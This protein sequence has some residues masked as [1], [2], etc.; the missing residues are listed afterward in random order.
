MTR[1]LYDLAA[2]DESL[3][4]SPYCWRAKL[5]LAHKNLEYETV[6]WH[7]TDKAAIAFSGGDKVP[8]LVDG[9]KVIADSQDIAEYL[10]ETYANEPPLFGEAPARALTNFIRAWTDRV[11]IPALAPILVPD[12]F[13]RLAEQD[14]AYFRSSREA[15]LGCTIEELATRRP[16]AITTFH[17]TLAP[18]LATLNAQKFIA[19]EAPN[20]ADHIVF[21]A[22][23]WGRLMSST[24]LL[25]PASPLNTWMTAVLGTYGLDFKPCG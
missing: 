23:Q 20:Y 2:A 24:P 10:D 11:L 19:G 13:P 7:L 4:F 9:D 17:A 3:R 12:I 1:L 14:K 22:L 18:L 15:R 8:V 5:A 16:S 21:G 25:E 6:P